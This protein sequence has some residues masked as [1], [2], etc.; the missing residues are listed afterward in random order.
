MATQKI[1][2]LDDALKTLGKID[3]VLRRE[4]VKRLK[5]DIKPI[6]LAI[7]AGIPKAPLSNWVAPKQSSAR[8]GTVEA[9]RSGAAGLPFWKASKAR[10]GV[11][12]SVRK[13]SQKGAKGKA[14]LITVRQRDGAGIAFDMAG[15][16]RPGNRLDRSLVSA[17]WGEASRVMWPTV[18]RHKPAVLASINRSVTKMEDLINEA[19]RDKGHTRGRPSGS[20]HFR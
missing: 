13:Q 15:R 8:R 9:G 14:I 12:A 20:P 10:S 16:K 1:R 19:L 2:G 4:G 18:E 7:K 17:G 3:P 5:G 11:S 6:V